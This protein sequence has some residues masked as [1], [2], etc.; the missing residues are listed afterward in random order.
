MPLVEILGKRQQLLGIIIFVYVILG[1]CLVYIILGLIVKRAASAKCID[2]PSPTII[3]RRA[4]S[5]VTECNLL[6]F[7]A[8]AHKINSPPLNIF[9]SLLLV[10]L[11]HLFPQ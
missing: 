8:K 2:G 3:L 1:L 6:S 7:G 4:C 10:D 11:I 5:V 9:N